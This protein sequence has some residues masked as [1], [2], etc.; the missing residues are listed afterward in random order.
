M[1]C[2][3]A[4]DVAVVTRSLSGA[5]QA[6]FSTV[7]STW[8]AQDWERCA[9]RLMSACYCFG[10]EAA[11]GEG[12]GG[13]V[14]CAPRAGGGGGG[15]GGG[16]RVGCAPRD[17]VWARL[18]GA[19]GLGRDRSSGFAQAHRKRSATTRARGGLSRREDDRGAGEGKEWRDKSDM[20][21]S[22]RVFGG[23]GARFSSCVGCPSCFAA[24]PFFPATNAKARK[25]QQQ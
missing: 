12:G 4:A 10:Y 16:V 7:V 8:F 14:G 13:R 24:E 3:T 9:P 18:E 25:Q 1:K 6:P 21:S 5:K 2:P 19:G 15:G 17:G 11:R 23:R 20:C 22:K